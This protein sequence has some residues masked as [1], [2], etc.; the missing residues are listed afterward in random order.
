MANDALSHKAELYLTGEM[1]HHD[2]IKAAEA[3]MTVVCTL[4]SN[5]ERAT[6]RRLKQRLEERLPKGPEWHL[7]QQDRD[8]FAVR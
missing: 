8:P 5:S 6:L 4:H 3:G 2:A 1:R 7:S